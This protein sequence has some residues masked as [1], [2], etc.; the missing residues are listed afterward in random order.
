M[1]NEVGGARAL[2]G[3]IVHRLLRRMGDEGESKTRQSSHTACDGDHVPQG[4]ELRSTHGNLVA[5]F[6][7]VFSFK[8]VVMT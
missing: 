2:S 8:A 6:S 3:S 1:T 4:D 7:W 5:V